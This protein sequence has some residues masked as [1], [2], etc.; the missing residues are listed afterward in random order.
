MEVYFYEKVS[1]MNK[2]K[3]V[4]L[5]LG[6]CLLTLG[7]LALGFFG[8][9]A[10]YLQAVSGFSAGKTVTLHQ[11]EN[12]RIEVSWPAGNSADRYCLEVLIPQDNVPQEDWAVESTAHIDGKT[13]HVLMPLPDAK[14]AIR[15]R[16]ERAYRFLIDQEDRYRFS[17]DA[18]FICDN[19]TAPAAPV[20][21]AVPDP[22]ADTVT[23][24]LSMEAG[25]SARVFFENQSDEPLMDV[26]GKEAVLSF[27]EG[28][29]LPMPGFHDTYRFTFE[30]CRQTDDY[31]FY[32]PHSA[33]I[34]V[35]R[36]DLLGLIVN[37]TVTENPGNSFDLSWNEA[38][39]DYYLLQYRKN[40][41]SKWETLQR[42]AV[43][44]ELSYTTDNLKPYT[45]REYRV[46]TYRENDPAGTEPMSKSSVT[47]LKTASSLVYST[48]WPIKDLTVY[49]DS[50]QTEEMGTATKGKALCILSLE[51]GMFQV[52]TPKGFGYIDSNYC[53]INLPEF[54]GELL[55]YDIAN[56][57]AS[58]FAI[59]DIEIPE[60]TGQVVVGYERVQLSENE[61]LVPYLYP[62]ALKLEK[63][64]LA[65]QEDGYYLKIYDSFRP[66]AA[67]QELY[68]FMVEMCPDPVP[69]TPV[70]NADGT[71][72][73]PT[74]EEGNIL[75][76]LKSDG[77]PLTIQEYMTDNNRYKLNYFL[78]KG[79]SRHNRGAALDL[80]L[81]KN[82][83]DVEMQ[84]A[85]HDL[86]YHSETAKNN[87]YANR[88]A[89][90]MKNNGFTGLVSE[91]WHFQD[92]DALNTLDLPALRNGV[93]P[94]GWMKD[95]NG[96]RYRRANGT[97]YE[98]CQKTIDGISYTFDANGYTAAPT[99]QN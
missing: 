60:V 79:T 38:K 11:Q 39:G 52:R 2:T 12:G 18:I 7:L 24:S 29:L 92:N 72:T 98:N 6:I 23:V 49:T 37:I 20:P 63:A 85:I 78:A 17:E 30:A 22:D 36:E 48:I 32:G 93:T 53:M 71:L 67:T 33:P 28:K 64:G 84:T 58:L 80:T 68:D 9:L 43:D 42:Y 21:S 46:V 83:D 34:T 65:A 5:I 91:W 96:W 94:E 4:L 90:Y 16:T 88:L 50:N 31:V 25:C 40:E 62:S 3:K 61:F 76:V 56:S 51:N 66:Q 26:P 75:Y 73:Y 74:D 55:K 59:H 70:E 1:D 97:Y 89:R 82:G 86:S 81:E 10:P 99:F 15:I 54:L 35:T 87:N 44:G 27:G 77:T 69:Q 41:S 45:Y 57:Y 8:F 47:P 95:V 19:F 13:S 14:R